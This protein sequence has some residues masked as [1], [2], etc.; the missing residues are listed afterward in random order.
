ML[1]CMFSETLWLR[2][3]VIRG[4]ESLALWYSL[5]QIPMVTF[6]LLINGLTFVRNLY[7]LVQHW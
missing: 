5:S 2:I 4:L 7:M 1:L 6:S 3:G